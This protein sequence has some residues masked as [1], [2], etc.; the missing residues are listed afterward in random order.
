LLQDYGNRTVTLVA[1]DVNG[2]IYQSTV[3]KTI[4]WSSN[5]TTGQNNR[6]ISF[7]SIISSQNG[8]STHIFVL[9]DIVKN[10]DFSLVIT[11]LLTPLHIGTYNSSLTYIDYYPKGKKQLSTYE[12][13]AF[14]T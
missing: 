13:I 9:S 14:K 2:T 10:N 4:L 8:T 3:D 7:Y 5:E 1:V 11:T 6:T 12:E